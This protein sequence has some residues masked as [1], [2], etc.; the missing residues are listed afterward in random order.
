MDKTFD[1]IFGSNYS[2]LQYLGNDN[3]TKG[4]IGDALIWL[5]ENYSF[6]GEDTSIRHPMFGYLT[7]LF[8]KDYNES[9]IESHIELL[10]LLKSE[11]PRQV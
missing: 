9:N 4:E 10:H 7:H 1:R 5:T 8:L 2:L 3:P 11:S 6:L